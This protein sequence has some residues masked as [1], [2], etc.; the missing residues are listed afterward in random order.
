MR[1]RRT[2]AVTSTV[3]GA[4]GLKLGL[5]LLATSLSLRSPASNSTQ[6]AQALQL[7][8][9]YR[10]C[11]SSSASSGSSLFPELCSSF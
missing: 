9:P 5:L 3:L 8:R 1:M 6:V 10:D 11:R 7:G 4:D 2:A